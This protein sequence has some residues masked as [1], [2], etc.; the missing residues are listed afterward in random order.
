MKFRDSCGVGFIADVE[1]KSSFKVIEKALEAV[2]NLTHRGAT[3]SDGRTG[4]GSGILFQLPHH[5]FLKEAKRIRGDFEAERVVVGTFFLSGDV[6]R[7]LNVVEEECRS[8]FGDCVLREVPVNRRECGEIARRALPEIYQVIAPSTLDLPQVYL[9]RRKLE[10]KL[11]EISPENYVVSLSDTLVVYKG[12]LLAPDLKKF[13][14]DLQEESLESSFVL[15]HQRYST[16]TNPKWSLAQPLR[17]IAH[18]GEINTITANRN[19]IKVLEPI[20][21]SPTFGGR[22]KEVLPLLEGGESDSASLDKVFELMVVA[23]I[24]PV[25]AINVLIPP[26]W[27]LLEGIS[28]DVK[29]FFQY[30][31][32]LMKPWDGPAAVVFTDGRV[33]GGKLDRN[34]LR[35]ARYIITESGEVIFGSE[36]GM[37]D[38]T[39]GEVL[40][41]GR[42]MPGETL[43]V[44]PQEKRVEKGREILERIASEF[45]LEREVRR[46]LYR[47]KKLK[48]V[49]PKPSEDMVKKLVSF[50]YSREELEE[51]VEYMAEM[52]KEPVFSMG[53]DTPI[54]NLLDRP[55]LLFRHFKQRFAQVTN[56][57]ID[58]I[59]EKAVMSL[60][61]R[62]GAKVNFLELPR[63]LPRRIEVDSPLLTPSELEE[64][65]SAGFLKVRTFPMEF[66]SSLREGIDELFL[67]VEKA[68][69]E[70]GVEIVILT[71][72]EAELPI[73]SLLAVSGLSAYLERKGLLHRVSV[74]VETGEARDTHQ[75]ATLIAFGAS[76]V[77]P[78]LVFEYLKAKELELNMPYDELE[79]NYKKAINEGLLKIM[80]KMG[81]SLLSSY[82]RSH[83]FDVVGIS[84]EV[85]EEFFPNT[86]SPIGGV[87]LDD[88]ERTVRE[89]VKKAKETDKVE[90]SGELRYRPGGVHHAWSPEVVR[91]IFKAAKS[92][93]YEDFKKVVEATRKRPTYLR[94]LLRIKSDRKPIP[95]EEVEPV[96][97]IVKRLMVPGMSIGALSKLAHE[98]IAEAMNILGAKSCSGEGGEDPERYGTVKNSKVKQ[99]ASGRFGVTPLYLASAEEIEIKIAQ[100]AKPG[101]GGHLPGHKVTPYI[102]SLRFS[103]PGVALISP[104][105]HHDIYSIEDLAQLIYDL[106]LANPKARVAVKLVAE[107]GVGT[108]ACGVAKAKAD[109]VQVSGGDG[110]TGASPLSS[111]KGAGLPWEIGLAETHRELVE[112]GLRDRVVLR[113]DGGFKTGR[114][115]VI[116]ALMGAEEF[117]FGT[118]AMIAEGCVMDR[119]CH[120]NRCPVGIATQDER[121]IKRFRGAVESVV[122]YFKLVA[123][124]VRHILAEM[125]YRSLDEIIGRYDLLEEDRELKERY[126]FA[127]NLDLSYI[128]VNPTT[129]LDRDVYPYTPVES[130][131]N[132]RI[133]KE[134]LPYIEK[135][136]KFFAEYEVKNTDRSVGVPLAY[137]IVKRFGS[138]G[139]PPNFIHLRFKGIAGQSFGAFLPPGVTVEVVGGA[140]DYVGK[141]L[142]G[143]T[144]VLRFPE[145]FKGE[146]NENV[147]AGNTLLYGATGGYLF[148]SGVVGER[149][150]VRNSGAI[151]VVEGAGQHACEYMVRGIVVILGNVGGNFGAGMTGGTAFV[152]DRDIEEKVNRDYVEVRKLDDRDYDVL[153]TLLSKHYKY[154]RS[155]MAALVLENRFLLESF[156]KVVPVGVRELEMKLSGTDR[157]PA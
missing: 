127:K 134:V 88:I 118:A 141:G 16:N 67:K 100:G 59:R 23:G 66:K 54:P 72:R 96:E 56:P 139:L 87:T 12:M 89:R 146:P 110:G 138:E 63:E 24:D 20:L 75:I 40:E 32:F 21:E 18:N 104:P 95:L 153:K 151:A 83:L 60:S 91:G 130:P 123:E 42:L 76:A 133:L 155:K 48:K 19:F 132:D 61:L 106:K 156:R 117:G 78:Y 65:K 73:P 81:I 64:I 9:L 121:R 102:A 157:L 17:L 39:F 140:N 36:V 47:L 50:C 86:F 4:D 116:A 93:K 101:E 30:A 8:S 145:E 131:L 125:G 94:D 41:S 44:D 147:I 108:V 135:G 10:R 136:E 29:A 98:V 154:T 5:F 34:G 111:I 143:G 45:S 144:I 142:G 148:A 119:D 53:D 128:L 112:N 85:V 38:V 137:H 77:H 97:S 80:S 15:F 51:V 126:P 115:V 114:D 68:I 149:F 26:A 33:V 79:A 31:S 113:V 28:E 37:T 6:D 150:A 152:L 43:L 3:L 74:I 52:G 82:H 49:E 129:R 27:E 107:S 105:P 14:L 58:P 124:D 122:N 55:Y 70:E 7:A 109:I 46:K 90:Y 84:E 13:Y 1:G 62:L 25:V 69:E 2:S 120:T 35:P 57:P 11:R 92:G 99:V 71:D 22:V 103:V